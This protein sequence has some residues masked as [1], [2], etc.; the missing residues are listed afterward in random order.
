MATLPVPI[1]LK[2]GPPFAGGPISTAS[3]LV[4]IGGA[5]DSRVRAHDVET[6]EELWLRE[7]P[8]SAQAN[9]MTYMRDGR[10]YVVF[11]AG[12]H[13]WFYPQG[14][15]DYVLAFALPQDALD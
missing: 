2:W 6:G 13:S 8:T 1:P 15:D 5:S 11:A 3:G 7:I 12:G 10:Q 9:P 4:F 14:I